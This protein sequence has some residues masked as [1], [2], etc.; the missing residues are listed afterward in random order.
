MAAPG[1][2]QNPSTKPC[3]ETCKACLRCANKNTRKE[4]K[5]C[6]GRHD[7][8]GRQDPDKEDY[9]SCTEGVLRWRHTNGKLYISKYQHNPFKGS[10]QQMP[11]TEDE[12][13][14]KE[15]LQ[16]MRERMDNPDWDPISMPGTHQGKPLD[17]NGSGFKQ[18]GR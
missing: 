12:R 3:W 1:S 4:C 6:S 10:I 14:W 17:D 15:Y 18:L 5:G 16:T 2:Y 7:P 13:D 11:E 9:C 8:V